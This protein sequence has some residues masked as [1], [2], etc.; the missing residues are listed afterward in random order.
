M[1]ARFDTDVLKHHPAAV[2]IDCGTNDVYQ[3]GSRDLTPLF[4]MVQAAEATGAHVIV[5]TLPPNAYTLLYPLNPA[6]AE[7]QQATHAYWNETIRTSAAAYGYTV[8]DYYP[9]M[10]LRDGRQNPVMFCADGVHP[11]SAGYAV[12]W[13]VLAPMVWQ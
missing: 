10:I 8:A 11:T 6:T 5:G 9:A 1:Q 2:V 12:M 13:Q 4:D 7:E 3:T